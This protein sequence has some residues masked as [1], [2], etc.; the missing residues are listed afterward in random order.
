[1]KKLFYILLFSPLFCTINAQEV[2]I[3]FG[4]MAGNNVAIDG[5][6]NFKEGRVHAD[7]TFGKSVGIY[8]VYDFI[9]KP[10]H[11]IDDFYYY[12]GIGL[13]TLIQSDFELGAAAEVGIE[14]RFPKSP[15]TLSLD[16]RPT[17]VI[18]ESTDF[19]WYGFGL[20][21]RYVLRNNDKMNK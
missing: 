7:I 6:Y 8:V 4:E 1:M 13:T 11:G 2:G 9:V 14:Y 10:I 5:V 20:N 3:R 19:H 15:L 17:I 12:L 16:Y 18:I 21:L